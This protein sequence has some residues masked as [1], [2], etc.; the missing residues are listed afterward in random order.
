M[1]L[2][3]P[4]IAGKSPLLNLVVIVLAA[5][6]YLVA[7]CGPSSPGSGGQGAL[8]LVPDSVAY[9]HVVDMDEVLQDKD[10]LESGLPDSMILRGFGEIEEKWDKNWGIAAQD[11]NSFV[12]T[13]D[14]VMI[15]EGL[16]ERIDFELIEDTLYDFSFEEDDYRGYALWEVRGQG[17]A[18]LEDDGYIIIG[19]T[20]DVKRALRLRDQGEG[21]LLQDNENPLKR[22]LDRAGTGL[23]VKVSSGC[24]T[25]FETRRCE[26][27]ALSVSTDSESYTLEHTVVLLFGSERTAERYV[28]D[29][30]EHLEDVQDSA[31]SLDYEVTQDGEFIEVQASIDWDDLGNCKLLDTLLGDK[32]LIRASVPPPAP[33]STPGLAVR[34]PTIEVVKEVVKEVP[35]DFDIFIDSCTWE[36]PKSDGPLDLNLTFSIVNNAPTTLFATYRIQDSKGN[37]FRPRGWGS[38]IT[39]YAKESDSRTLR[40]NKFHVGAFD[41]ELVIAV[42]RGAI[43]VVPLGICRVTN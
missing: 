27:G 21:S 24:G 40:T 23:L 43:S 42:Q 2:H 12:L 11:I 6:V 30:E 35:T 4:S 38:S 28:E 37:I 13:S 39:I 33:R 22:V 36:S 15:L 32:C 18:L 1:K 25:F 3:P 5:L 41:L 19:E 7:G 34:K 17:V 20:D 8:G 9:V 26:A 31:S 10:F 14:G 16:D 29:F